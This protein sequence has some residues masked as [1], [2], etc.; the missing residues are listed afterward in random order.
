MNARQFFIHLCQQL[1]IG[2]DKI[3]LQKGERWIQKRDGLSASQ[4]ILW[5]A[6][7]LLRAG[8]RDQFRLRTTTIIRTE[9]LQY[10]QTEFPKIMLHLEHDVLEAGRHWDYR[11][12]EDA[13]DLWKEVWNDLMKEDHFTTLAS[14]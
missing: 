5:A 10:I 4:E 3:N 2:Q 13:H 8:L 1:G 9:H 11:R 14:G 12:M 6:L 7:G